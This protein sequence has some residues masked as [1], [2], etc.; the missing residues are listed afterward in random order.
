[1]DDKLRRLQLYELEM[2]NTFV[3][4][5]ERNGL[6][7]YLTGGTLLGAVRHNGFIPWDDDI[8]VA[9]PREDYD[10]FARIADGELGSEYFFQSADTDPYYFLSYAKIRKNGTTVYE[11]RFKNARFHKG[12]YIDVFPLDPCPA[13]GLLC[14]FLFNIM[15]VM[16]RRGTED[17]GEECVTYREWTG[18]LGHALLGILSPQGLVRFRKKLLRISGRLSCGKYVASYSGAYGYLKEVYPVKWYEKVELRFEDGTFSAP[19]A[20]DLILRRYYG[21]TYMEIPSEGKRKRHT[22]LAA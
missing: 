3:R 9:M 21:D 6:R 11:E 2:L 7:Y 19:A 17:S 5:C 10:R 18:R 22:V 15:A 4:I 8:D 16:N 14:R 20:F 13:P 12:V 1:M